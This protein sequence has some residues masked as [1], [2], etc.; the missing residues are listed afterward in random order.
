MGVGAKE[1]Y[2]L[3]VGQRLCVNGQVGR[4][5]VGANNVLDLR[6]QISSCLENCLSFL[7][8]YG[9]SLS[10]FVSQQDS[11]HKRHFGANLPELDKKLLFFDKYFPLIHWLENGWKIGSSLR[12]VS[13]STP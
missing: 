6:K 3:A 7:L 11:S 10:L 13:A 9:L 1:T 5:S 8:L 12:I 2:W 4:Q